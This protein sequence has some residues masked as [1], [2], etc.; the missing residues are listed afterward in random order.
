MKK[1][2][3][4]HL[5]SNGDCLMATTI[6]RQIKHNNPHCH[7]TWAISYKCKQV[8]ENNPFIDQFWEIFYEKN[9]SPYKDVWV[10]VKQEAEKRKSEGEFDEIIYTQIYPDN[11]YLFDGT[12]RSTTF[13]IYNSPITVPVTPVIRLHHDEVE[14]VREFAEKHGLGKFKHI[15]LCECSP[16]SGQSFLTPDLMLEVSEKIAKNNHEVIFII[17]SHLKIGSNNP[18]VIDASV[19][20]YRENAELSRYCTMLVGCSSGITWLLTSDWAKQIPMIQFLYNSQNPF[21][22]ASVIY[23]FEYWGLPCDHILEST[24]SDAGQ[25]EKIINVSLADFNE[26][27]NKYGEQ[28]HPELNL[29]KNHLNKFRL[30]RFSKSLKEALITINCF[31]ERNRNFVKIPRLFLFFL[32][33]V[34]IKN[35]VLKTIKFIFPASDSVHF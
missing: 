24:Q 29:L 15:V 23:D 16:A 13:R 10:K 2:L 34:I 5:V 6:A 25:I 27:R 9:Q 14:R 1:F 30:K 20:T 28:L 21:S 8:I 33:W 19:L 32:I 22:F 4:V 17:S 26:A 35:L 3:I 12:T 11:T 7:I 18:H 31:S